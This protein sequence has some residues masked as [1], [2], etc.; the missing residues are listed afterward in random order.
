[1]LDSVFEQLVADGSGL[2]LLAGIEAQHAVTGEQ[3]VG[4]APSG[5]SAIF[6]ILMQ[7]ILLSTQNAQGVIVAEDRALARVPRQIKRR[8]RLLQVDSNNPYDRQIEAA[9]HMRPDLLIVQSLDE[10]SAAPAFRAAAHGLRVLSQVDTVLRGASVARHLLEKGI[11]RSQL[12]ALRWILTMQRLPVLC[13]HCK[14][15]AELSQEQVGRLCTRYPHLQ[16]VVPQLLPAARFHRA[17]GCPQCRG[18]GYNGDLAVFDFFRND[19]HQ[20]EFFTQPALLS[21]EE[22]AL[23]LGAEGQVDLDDLQDLENNHLR[24]TYQMLTASQRA[25]TASNSALNSKLLEL[26]AA[27]RVLLQR[28]EVL[29]SLQELG[30]ALIT[31]DSLGELA[32]RI[33][34]RASELCG[35][36][37]AVL[38]LLRGSGDVPAAAEVLAV[39]GWDATKV[40]Q[41]LDPARVFDAQ[42][43]ARSTQFSHIPP[44]LGSMP[45]E[46]QSSTTNPPR[47]GIRTGLRVPLVV[48]NRQVGIMIVQTTQKDFFT[49][50]ETALLQTFANQAALAIQRAGLVDDLRAKIDQLQ[51]A[52]AGL[53]KKERMERELELARQV[54]QSLLPHEFPKVPGYALSAANEPAR[55]VGGDFYDVILLDDDHFGVVIAD[56]AD[57]GLPAAL[58]MAL[59]RSLLL[60]EAR[61]APSPRVALENVNRLLLELGELNGFVSVF[62]GVIQCS[63]HQLTYIR[64]GHERPLLLRGGEAVPLAGEGTVLGVVASDSLHL[65]EQTLKL[66]PGDRLALYTDGLTDVMDDAGQFFGLS[67]L[68]DLLCQESKKTAEGLCRAVFA[69]LEQYRGQAEQFDD[70]TLLVL[71]V[72]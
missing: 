30:Q 56:V 6:N 12:S 61:R 43:H 48:Q 32:N 34:R 70:M 29:V 50:G 52:Q 2:I 59:T 1:M 13:N 27:N 37:R 42:P 28:T 19:P 71:E 33:C 23:R 17:A 60:A 5:T 25:L 10:E 49:P 41:R 24:Q 7:E 35:A 67:R 53:V 36:D 40:G 20:S 9:I 15:S 22:Y 26:E 14:R 68:A 18:S 66:H 57:K 69:S 64:A 3:P 72:A 54:Q 46:Q 11:D 55:Q 16:S 39:R 44:G 21:L 4:L 45:A 62:Y 63:T 47:H 31:S 58:Y 51:A 8:V 38:Y 65:S